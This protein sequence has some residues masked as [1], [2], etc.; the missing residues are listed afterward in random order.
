[1]SAMTDTLK[2]HQ[3]HLNDTLTDNEKRRSIIQKLMWDEK[4]KIECNTT[5][6]SANYLQRKSVPKK[7][8]TYQ[9]INIT[10]IGR[11]NLCLQNSTNTL[12]FDSSYEIE[13]GYNITS[14][15][16][17]SFICF[18]PHFVNSRLENGKKVYYDFT[19]DFDGETKKCF[20]YDEEIDYMRETK[21]LWNE[22]I[23]QIRVRKCSCGITFSK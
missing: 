6:T 16:C 18:E 23:F 12:S 11:N 7:Y 13:S 8:R 21:Q 20:I 19:K 22:K 17:S 1:M 4:K 15:P 2:N 5:S 9:E 10:P 14:C 3:K